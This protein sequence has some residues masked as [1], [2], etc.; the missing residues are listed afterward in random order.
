MFF[1]KKKLKSVCT[2]TEG[3][4]IVYSASL[5]MLWTVCERKEN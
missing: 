5:T 1:Y 4:I 2:L 3:F